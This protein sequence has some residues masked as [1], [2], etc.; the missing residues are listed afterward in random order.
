MLFNTF[1]HVWMYGYFA[2]SVSRVYFIFLGF[3]RQNFSQYVFLG[4]PYS[5]TLASMDNHYA[6]YPVYIFFSVEY[7]VYLLA[8]DHQCRMWSEHPCMDY[9]RWMQRFLFVFVYTFLYKNICS[10]S[11]NPFFGYPHTHTPSP[12]HIQITTLV[13]VRSFLDQ[14]KHMFPIP[15]RNAHASIQKSSF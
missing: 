9:K 15:T 7:S 1:I 2:A 6:N 12:L 13:L 4:D 5:S 10:H 14:H 8:M 11:I 3:F